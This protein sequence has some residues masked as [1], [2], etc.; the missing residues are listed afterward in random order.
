MEDVW[1]LLSYIAVLQTVL[2]VAFQKFAD[3]LCCLVVNHELC[4]GGVANQKRGVECGYR[5]LSLRLV[6]RL[7]VSHLLSHLVGSLDIKFN[8]HVTHPDFLKSG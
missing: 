8:L 6:K 7:H 5:F 4:A 2:K 3:G 1:K